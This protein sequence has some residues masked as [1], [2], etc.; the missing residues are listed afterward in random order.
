[1]RPK[2]TGG[3]LIT[4]LT[5][6][7]C[8]ANVIFALGILVYL[9]C[10]F[11]AD[12]AGKSIVFMGGLGFLAAGAVVSTRA[13]VMKTR[14][15]WIRSVPVVWLTTAACTVIALDMWLR[16]LRSSCESIPPFETFVFGGIAVANTLAILANWPTPLMKV[17]RGRRSLSIVLAVAFAFGIVVMSACFGRLIL[18]VHRKI[19]SQMLALRESEYSGASQTWR[20]GWVITLDFTGVEITDKHIERLGRFPMLERLVLNDTAIS[21]VGIASIGCVPNLQV[22]RLRRTRVTDLCAPHLAALCSL[23]SID[24]SE[25]AVTDE[26]ARHL[27]SMPVLRH[28]GLADTH[29]TDESLRSLSA[30]GTL[31]TVNVRGTPV[32]I[33]GIREMGR[34]LPDVRVYW[35]GDP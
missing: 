19:E 33:G 27:A 11:L 8:V 17:L 3:G 30:V 24:L 28:V 18:D 16:Q 22:L 2:R 25:T 15:V 5:Y 12:M 1:M 35:D 32:T 13:I 14:R 6:G 29:I 31:Y 23:E 7:T 20:D 4:M 21:D 10:Y 9:Y 26:V 34:R